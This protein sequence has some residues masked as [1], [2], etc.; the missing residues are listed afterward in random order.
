M[1]AT[2][3]DLS[4]V[5]AAPAEQE[6][7]LLAY[8]ALTLPGDLRLD[9]LTLR[10]TTDGRLTVS[11]PDRRTPSGE[12]RPILRPLTPA[13]RAEFE[14]AVIAEVRRQRLRT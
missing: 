8:V 10:R 13:A 3:R 7:G 4:V 2:F 12:R 5:D 1:R 6:R 14:A 11:I 9:G